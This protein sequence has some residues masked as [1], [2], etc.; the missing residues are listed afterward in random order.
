[1]TVQKLKQY[2]YLKD[3]IKDIEDEIKDLKN[4]ETTDVVKSSNSNFPYTQH[5]VKINGYDSFAL[6]LIKIKQQKKIELE[7]LK[8][9]IEQFIDGIQESQIRRIIHLKYI[10][11]HT[12]IKVAMIL[13]GN[14][15]E[16]SVRKVCTRYLK[17]K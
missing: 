14:N 3:E 12:W 5:S 15:T 7:Q 4:Q 13:G 11:G 1:M 6:N 9:E 16:E 2:K 8:L 10:K 17:K